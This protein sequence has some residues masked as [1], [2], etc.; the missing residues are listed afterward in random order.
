[1]NERRHFSRILF[2][3]TAYLKQDDN[4]WTTKIHDLSLNGALVEEPINFSPNESN[5]ILDLCLPDSD[6]KL[7]MLTKLVYNKDK[8]LGLQC[9][10]IDVDSISHLRRMLELNLGDASLLNRELEHFIEEHDIT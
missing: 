4:M 10:H 5:L 8:Q 2:D 6:I 1:M 9:V 7:I 3:T